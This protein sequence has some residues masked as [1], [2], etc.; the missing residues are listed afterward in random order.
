MKEL[1]F[2]Q[3]FEQLEEAVQRLEAGDLPLAEALALFEEGTR[4]ARLCERQLS[5]AEL[6]VRQIAPSGEAI[7]FDDWQETQ[8]A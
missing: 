8:G 2:E 1:T 7:P 5:G 6:R 3:A 4:L